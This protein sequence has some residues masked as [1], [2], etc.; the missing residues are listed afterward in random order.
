MTISCLTIIDK[1]GKPILFRSYKNDVTNA[2]LD[3]LN[4]K[5]LEFDP[6]AGPSLIVAEEMAFFFLRHGNIMI[7][8][9]TQE[10]AN[11]LMIFSFLNSFLA[12]LSECFTQVDADRVRDNSILIYE[13]MDEVIDNGHPLVTDFKALKAHVTS[14]ATQ[15]DRST[16]PSKRVDK[17]AVA[18]S[19]VAWRTGTP[20]YSKNEVYLDVVEKINMVIGSAGQ[21]LKS[22]VEGAM[23][24]DCRLT[25]TPEL[26]LGINDKKFLELSPDRANR[27]GADVLDLKFHQC[28][29]LARFEN[30]RTISFIPPDGKFDLISYR[31]ESTF[32]SL[33]SAEIVYDK[34]T[35]TKL[36]FHVKAKSLYKEKVA[37]TF[38]ELLVPVPAEAQNLRVKLSAGSFKYLPEDDVIAWKVPSVAGKRELHAEVRLD[39]PTLAP[40]SA[41]FKS[42][43]IGVQFEIPYYTL[44]GLNVKYLKISEQA[45]YNAMSWVRYVARNGDF[46]IRTN[47]TIL[48]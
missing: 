11:A 1:K 23:C 15:L 41:A 28:V 7:V 8:A 3:V 45:K 6:D 20:K 19:A 33:F 18:V 35:E 42:R 22:E 48:Q 24:M 26:I 34:Q 12:L 40:K 32:K 21:V 46:V 27:K 39:V 30:D 47:E 37:A 17:P 2:C 25:G 10:N 5:L 13:L 36:H 9:L 31:M 29:R 4:Q 38:L 16:Q 14:A 43:P 44:S